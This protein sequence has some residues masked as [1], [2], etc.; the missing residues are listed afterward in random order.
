MKKF[1]RFLCLALVAVMLCATLASCGGPAKDPKEAAAALKEN[2]Y[3]VAVETDALVTAGKDGEH[4]TINYCSDEEAATK[5]YDELK[6]SQEEAQAK[7]DEAEKELK[8]AKEEL[9]GMEDGIEKGLKEAAVKILEE[10][11]AAAQ[12]LANVEIGQSGNMVWVGTAQ[13]IK[14][15][16]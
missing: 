13:A 9:E 14:D 5:I 7:L 3:T 11:V 8:E 12:K 10:G 6:K 15:A 2:G 4:I 1:A 16:K